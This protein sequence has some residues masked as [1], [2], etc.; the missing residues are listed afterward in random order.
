LT[1][2]TSAFEQASLDLER[3][4]LELAE[5]REN[6]NRLLGLWGPSANWS[7]TDPLPE[8][9]ATDPALDDLEAVAVRCRLDVSAARKQSLLL[10]NALELARDSRF[11]GFVEVGVHAHQDPEGPVLVGPT[12]SLELPIFDQRQALIAKLEAQYRQTQ[13]RLARVAIE[14]RSDVRLAVAELTSARRRVERYRTSLLPLRERGVDEAQLLYNGMQIGL[15]QLLAA[16]QAQVEAYRG[17]LGALSDYWSARADLEMAVGGRLER[18]E[19]GAR[20]KG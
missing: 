18:P 15:Y 11:F 6:V 8:L 20:G 5:A 12:L 7:L 16:R 1:Q 9:P 4:E 10:W 19:A 13:H 14:A 3:E 2:E 17:Y